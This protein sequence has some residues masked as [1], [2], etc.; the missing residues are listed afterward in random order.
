[1]AKE[2]AESAPEQVACHACGKS[3]SVNAAVKVEPYTGLLATGPAGRPFHKACRPPHRQTACYVCHMAGPDDYDEL[4]EAGWS[5]ANCGHEVIT[6]V[7]GRA[8]RRKGP[9][10]PGAKR[11]GFRHPPAD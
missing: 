2:P 8:D 11:L 9:P 7:W 6:F 5:C 3:M 4:E 1:M 10:A